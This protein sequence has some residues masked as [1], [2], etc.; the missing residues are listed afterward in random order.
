VSTPHPLELD[1]RLVVAEAHG[2]ELHGVDVLEQRLGLGPP[3]GVAQDEPEALRAQLAQARGKPVVDEAA[4]GDLDHDRGRVQ[5]QRTLVEQVLGLDAHVGRVTA[6]DE[7]GGPHRSRGR[8]LVEHELVADR[9]QR[10]VKDRTPRHDG[11]GCCLEVR[12]GCW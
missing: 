2:V 4:R 11:E 7:V 12:R 8:A 6:C 3:A 10:P 1:E 9:A 5:L